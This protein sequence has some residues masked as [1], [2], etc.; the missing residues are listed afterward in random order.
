MRP[1]KG[2][3]GGIIIGIN[4]AHAFERAIGLVFCTWVID[5]V[6][7]IIDY[8]HPRRDAL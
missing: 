2:S 4:R 8:A 6:C 5:G 1:R 7:Q 3:L